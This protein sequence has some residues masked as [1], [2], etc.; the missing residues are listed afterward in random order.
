[1][2]AN[3]SY[4]LKQTIQFCTLI[5]LQLLGMSLWMLKDWDNQL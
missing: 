1:V 5:P 4:Q 3:A 2:K